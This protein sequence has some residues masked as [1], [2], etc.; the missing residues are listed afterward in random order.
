MNDELERLGNTERAMAVAYSVVGG[1]LV[2]AALGAALDR[3]LGTTPWLFTICLVA[4]LA[5][6]LFGLVRLFGDRSF[7]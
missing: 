4:G 7:S 2:G 5:I 6:A 3:L 1:L